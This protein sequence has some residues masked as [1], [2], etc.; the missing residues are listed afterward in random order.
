MSAAEPVDRGPD[1]GTDNGPAATVI[2]F[3]QGPSKRRH[4]RREDTVPN[5]REPSE[6]SASP[7]QR[8][9]D[10][11]E[12]RFLKCERTLTDPETAETY[13]ITLD[14]V[15]TMLAGALV[16]KIV[17]DEQRRELHAMIDGMK[18]APGLL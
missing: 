14:L 18:A 7:Q 3:R 10:S 15:S 16:N 5:P 2:L 11:V 13:Q 17:D 1:G 9:A 12:A 4:R 8:L 6:P